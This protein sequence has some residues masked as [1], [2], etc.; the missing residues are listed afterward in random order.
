MVSLSK[1][2][3]V[4][5]RSRATNVYSFR[6]TA[7]LFLANYILI[8]YW[9]S[10]KSRREGEMNIDSYFFYKIMLT[11]FLSLLIFIDM[12]NISLVRT[13]DSNWYCPGVYNIP[14]IRTR[15]KTIRFG[16]NA[17]SSQDIPDDPF[18]GVITSARARFR[19]ITLSEWIIFP[20][21]LIESLRDVLW[22]YWYKILLQRK[23][24][25]P[26]QQTFSGIL[27]MHFWGLKSASELSSEVWISVL[28]ILSHANS[29][30]DV[31]VQTRVLV[32]KS[33]PIVR[34]MSDFDPKKT[35]RRGRKKDGV[36]IPEPANY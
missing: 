2:S 23:I 21:K 13:F 34:L 10:R 22:E 7:G 28:R 35:P 33:Q 11:L 16:P 4:V 14:E 26:K 9:K 1:E 36:F 6:F 18:Y 17:G 19:D 8:L 32:W 31:D 5:S 3:P 24:S 25:W 29:H 30:A 27:D 15:T 20:P 12:T